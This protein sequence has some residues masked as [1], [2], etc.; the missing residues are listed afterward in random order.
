MH[1]RNQESAK[2]FSLSVVEV[3]RIQCQ[4]QS[5][6]RA[7]PGV[8][9]S[10]WLGCAVHRGKSFPDAS[11][12]SQEASDARLDDRPPYS[13]ILVQIPPEIRDVQAARE[14]EAQIAT[15]ND[16]IRVP[17]VPSR[18][19]YAHAQA[20]RS[21]DG[22][23]LHESRRGRRSTT[24]PEYRA[25]STELKPPKQPTEITDP[26]VA[27]PDAAISTLPASVMHTEW[28]V[29]VNSSQATVHKTLDSSLQQSVQ[30]IHE[31]T[32]GKEG[33]G[34]QSSVLI[35]AQDG[36]SQAHEHAK[37]DPQS[38]G[39]SFLEYSVLNV[40]ARDTDPTDH[41]PVDAGGTIPG[42]RT[43]YSTTKTPHTVQTVAENPKDI[44]KRIAD[45]IKELQKQWHD[46]A[47][48]AHNAKAP[49]AMTAEELHAH[50][51]FIQDVLERGL[52]SEQPRPDGKSVSLHPIVR[53]N[54]ITTSEFEFRCVCRY[55]SG[56]FQLNMW[57][58]SQ[59][60][61]SPSK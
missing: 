34:V 48:H 40:K 2:F 13:E 29:P 9:S 39:T 12:R 61:H 35:V 49:A 54:N 33:L 25:T 53:V 7:M 30:Q 47:M 19:P 42:P 43:D 41:D 31:A 5:S 57:H 58:L 27:A 44:K 14:D 46:E 45:K 36:I 51:S 16:N 8:C 28:Q 21:P 60:H 50:Q 1:V 26:P 23:L 11:I 32:G 15:L 20:V 22:V 52:P 56:L 3:S 10:P 24:S 17:L 55:Q 4:G 18:N 59:A 37:S 38:T 6:S